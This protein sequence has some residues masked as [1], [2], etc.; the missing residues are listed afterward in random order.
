MTAAARDAVLGRIRDG[1]GRVPGGPR[2]QPPAI[3]HAGRWTRPRCGGA[4]VACFAAK[5][6]AS[7]CTVES[8]ADAAAVVAAVERLCAAH[9]HAAR[10]AS[11]G[12]SVAPALRELPWPAAWTINYGPGRLREAVA[13]TDAL[14]GIA[15]TGSAVVCS[16][17]DRPASL[18]FLPDLHICLLR[19][20]DIVTHL[21]DA[22][23]KLRALEVWPRAV[24]IISAPSRTADVAQIVVRPAHGPKA[25]HFILVGQP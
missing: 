11:D 4:D 25:L 23:P 8:V 17:A 6:Q 18:N 2:D 7:Q 19:A 20:V 10:I 3:W 1:L 15:E 13:V 21:E 9:E 5:A 14:A 24:N 22:W 16:H 12:I